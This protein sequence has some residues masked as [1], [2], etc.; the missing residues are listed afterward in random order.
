MR[1]TATDF[2]EYYRPSKCPVRV[3]LRQRGV[4]ESPPGPYEQVIERLGREHERRH[5]ATF[6]E[7][8]DFSGGELYERAHQTEQAVADGA[9]VI[10]QGVLR[11]EALLGGTGCEVVGRPDFLIRGDAGSYVV[12]DSKMSRRINGKDHAEILLQLGLYGWLHEQALGQPPCG[13]EVHSGT[14]EIVVLDYEGGA[15]AL[16][17]L[18]VILAIKQASAELSSPVGWSKCNGCG[19][20]ERCWP[21]AVKRRDVAL[22]Q[23]VDQGLAMALR[24]EGIETYDELLGSFSEERLAVFKRPWGQSLRKVGKSAGGILRNAQALASGEEIVIQPPEI[25]DSPNYVMF[26]LEGLPPQLED[27]GKIYLW[28]MQVYG[29]SPGEFT[30]A[31]AGFG[32]DGDRQGWEDFLSKAGHILDEYGD[33]PFVH[34]HSYE[35]T[36]LNLYVDRYGDPDGVAVRVRGNLLDLLPVTKAAVALPLPSTSL[37]VVEQYIGFERSQEQYGGDWAM[38]KFIE[39]T[40]MVDGDRRA[41]LMGEIL[42]YNKEDLAATWAVLQWLK[43]K[44]R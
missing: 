18:E 27:P 39:A 1:L 10:Y 23:G 26:D 5:L 19:Y 35:K 41:K 31:V 8:Q 21:V 14:G 30:A 34:W 16:A 4:Q 33:V 24:T 37:K 17:E 29:E 28:G 12:R 36:H 11:A 7:V 32:E 40:E 43:S 2:L 13:L 44:A 15:A 42:K 38:A 25:Q 20:F 3:F 6:P 22:V 9:P